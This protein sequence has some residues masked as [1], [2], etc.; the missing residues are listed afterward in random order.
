MR[1]LWL[2]ALSALV[3]AAA[4][5]GS[6]PPGGGNNGGTDGGGDPATDGPNP[7]NPL[8]EVIPGIWE[9]VAFDGQAVSC[10]CTDEVLAGTST[11][12]DPCPCA[13]QVT[14]N[15]NDPD[16]TADSGP[17]VG[18]PGDACI[19]LYTYRTEDDKLRVSVAL[20]LDG[21]VVRAQYLEITGQV[22]DGGWRIVLTQSYG[23]DDGTD[24]THSTEH[25]KLR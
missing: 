8:I 4:C 13:G 15:P 3:I 23:G 19:Y 7:G 12:A 10:P 11:P 17:F 18:P 22:L 21:D 16:C 25:R 5:G 24:L 20:I 14:V 1:D 6:D 2:S 9:Q